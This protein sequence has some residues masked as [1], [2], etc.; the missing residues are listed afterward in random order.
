MLTMLCCLPAEHIGTKTAVQIRSHAQKFFNK[1]EK[2]KEA[3][4]VPDKGV[5]TLHISK[6]SLLCS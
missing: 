1:L 2:K 3:G 4:E 6:W 5:C